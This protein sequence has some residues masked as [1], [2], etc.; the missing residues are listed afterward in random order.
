MCPKQVGNSFF[1][2][3]YI[4]KMLR[5]LYVFRVFF[6]YFQ[7]LHCFVAFWTKV[8]CLC[9]QYPVSLRTSHA[10]SFFYHEEKF[11]HCFFFFI[12]EEDAEHKGACIWIQIRMARI[13]M[14]LDFYHFILLHYIKDLENIWCEIKWD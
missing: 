13:I 11:Y 3:F 14:N 9:I 10:P 5:V 12:I 6:S 2:C 1:F 8:T 4:L 7:I